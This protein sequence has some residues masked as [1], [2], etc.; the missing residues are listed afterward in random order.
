MRPL[1]AVELEQ[2]VGRRGGGHGGAVQRAA[3]VAA[4][5]A[6]S[7]STTGVR[8]AP[9]DL[10]VDRSNGAMLHVAWERERR[11]TKRE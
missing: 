9:G 5:A 1:V 11:R 4:V 7:A 6:I 10:R 8:A 3:A 2:R